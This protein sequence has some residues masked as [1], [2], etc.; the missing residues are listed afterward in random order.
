MELHAALNAEFANSVAS[1]DAALRLN[2]HVV[3]ILQHVPGLLNSDVT[4]F[5]FI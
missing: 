1:V 5:G 4:A 2:F 3:T